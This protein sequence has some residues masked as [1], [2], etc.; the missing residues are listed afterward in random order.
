[1]ARKLKIM[2]NE[3]H[4]FIKTLTTPERLEFYAN[5]LEPTNHKIPSYII[6][7]NNENFFDVI[8]VYIGSFAGKISF[9]LMTKI[10][11]YSDTL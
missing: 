6:A 4:P 7:G 3:K 8:V 10:L 2:E 11:D 5:F 1:M 9:E